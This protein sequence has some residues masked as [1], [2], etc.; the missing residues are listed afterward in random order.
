MVVVVPV[1]TLLNYVHCYTV[2]TVM[3]GLVTIQYNASMKVLV[4][5][6]K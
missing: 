1:C 5:I 3:H 4:H 2:L 6:H